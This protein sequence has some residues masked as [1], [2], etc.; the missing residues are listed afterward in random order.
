MENYKTLRSLIAVADH[1]KVYS[2]LLQKQTAH[3]FYSEKKITLER[4]YAAYRPVI[5]SLI[6]R[7]VQPPGM[8]IVVKKT[9][10]LDEQYLY[11]VVLVNDAYVAPPVGE[12][13]YFSGG[14]DDAP[15]AGHYDANLDKHHQYFGFYGFP[16]NSHIDSAVEIDDDIDRDMALAEILWEL[17]FFGLTEEKQSEYH[18]ELKE[19][20]K[21]YETKIKL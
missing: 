20:F 18:A 5:D 11:E 1:D 4:I 9:D 2:I 7:E 10:T 16:W 8:T 17:T 19:S 21:A 6:E 15:P 14:S 12:L 3:C 13:P